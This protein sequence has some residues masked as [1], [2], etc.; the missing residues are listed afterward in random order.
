VLAGPRA[1]NVVEEVHDMTA[2][3]NESWA[4]AVAASPFA[5][6]ATYDGSKT[7]RP[8][9]APTTTGSLIWHQLLVR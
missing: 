5:E 7:E 9:V 4:R 1:G 3:T 8:L 2:W 6:A